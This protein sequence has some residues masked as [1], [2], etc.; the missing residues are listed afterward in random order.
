MVVATLVWLRDDELERQ[1]GR[2][3][4]EGDSLV[5]DHNTFSIKSYSLPQAPPTLILPD[6]NGFLSQA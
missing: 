2:V 3:T 4:M 5:N 1:K 6:R